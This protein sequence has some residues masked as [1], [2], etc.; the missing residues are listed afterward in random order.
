MSYEVF[1]PESMGDLS[2]AEM[3]EYRAKAKFTIIGL[4]MPDTKIESYADL[5]DAL[6]NLEVKAPFENKKLIK[7]L[8]TSAQLVLDGV[9]QNVSISIEAQ[10]QNAGISESVTANVNINKPYFY[11]VTDTHNNNSRV[12]LGKHF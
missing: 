1:M 7:P 9:E 2:L 8:T 4:T 11:A 5:N 12:I 3:N 6:M 10:G